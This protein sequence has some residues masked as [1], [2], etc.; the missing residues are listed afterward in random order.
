M[1]RRITTVVALLAVM[2]ALTGI[3]SAGDL[4]LINP[5]TNQPFPVQ[6]IEIQIP[7]DSI[8]GNFQANLNSLYVDQG[9]DYKF[10]VE[11]TAGNPNDL[12]ITRD[13]LALNGQVV[14]P[15]TDFQSL[16]ADV[17]KDPKLTTIKVK[18]TA[19]LNA[20]YEFVI[21]LELVNPQ[22]GVTDQ[23]SFSRQI[24]LI[25]PNSKLTKTVDKT[26]VAPGE[27]VTYTYTETNTGNVNLTNVRV[28]DDKC[29]P[30]T[31]KSGDTNNDG[32]LNPGESWKYECTAA[33]TAN[34]TNTATGHGN[35]I[36]DGR[37]IDIDIAP[38]QF[39]TEMAQ[40]TVNVIPPEGCKDR[41]K[42]VGWGTLGN[43]VAPELTFKIFAFTK[44]MPKGTVETE[45]NEGNRIVA[46]EINSVKTNKNADP[47]TGEIKGKAMFNNEGPYDFV[48]NVKD[49]GQP[50][51]P[52]VSKD[53]FDIS[54]PAKNYHKSGTLTSG[55]LQVIY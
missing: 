20:I 25:S 37:I 46:T 3:A 34:T 50:A 28:D 12:E 27:T 29:S 33:I 21:R 30:V 31:F 38:P 43:K 32:L 44:F 8:S 9:L 23:Q 19:P 41:C 22:N 4:V 47:K 13:S 17:Y 53:T 42:V 10:T 14:N 24:T 7:G 49:G 54:I 15:K 26:N 52:Y 39:P 5:A 16:G 36:V 40:T 6:L 1:K 45:D 18:E 35:P 48:V 55:D 2:V 11:I 51:S